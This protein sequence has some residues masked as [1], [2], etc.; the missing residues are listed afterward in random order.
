M[1]DIKFRLIKDGKVVGHEWHSTEGQYQEMVAIL[2]REVGS[3]TWAD[4][5]DIQ[6]KQREPVVVEGS[7]YILHDVKEQYT[8]LKDSKGVE[9]YDSDTI[10][11]KYKVPV[12]W[13]NDGFYVW[14]NMKFIA[15]R[16]WLDKRERAGCP[17]E[18]I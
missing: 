17:S 15:L 6:I 9:I 10:D 16:E 13:V 7:W 4:I 2:H 18:V 3:N 8:G 12:K 14:H 5:L 11:K 1:R